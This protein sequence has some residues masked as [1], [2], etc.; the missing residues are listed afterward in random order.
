MFMIYCINIQSLTQTNVF[1]TPP[2]RTHLPDT[3]VL[4][5]LH[6]E[7][8]RCDA[9]PANGGVRSGIS[10]QQLK[11]EH[12]LS[13]GAVGRRRRRRRRAHWARWRGSAGAIK[14]KSRAATIL[15]GAC[16]AV[17][18]QR[19]PVSGAERRRHRLK[20]EVDN[21][22]VCG[23]DCSMQ[24]GGTEAHFLSPLAVNRTF[25]SVRHWN[26]PPSP[27]CWCNWHL[28]SFFPSLC[29]APSGFGRL[30]F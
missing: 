6:L 1:L 4:V 7:R 11:A 13:F 3:N 5:H 14:D 26:R 25:S 16:Q 28:G 23:D 17:C 8:C 29:R 27:R 10:H 21:R 22:G 20:E 9:W 12:T 24:L 2:L 18:W 15:I 19:D 30:P